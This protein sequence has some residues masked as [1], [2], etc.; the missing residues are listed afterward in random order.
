[1][2]NENRSGTNTVKGSRDYYVIDIM[3][4]LK[5]LWMRAWIIVLAGII[6]AGIG[7]SVAAF[8]ITPQY[9]SSVMLY[10]NNSSFSLG[11]TNFSISSSE[12]MAAQS[13]VKTYSVILKNRTTLDK[14]I[15]KSGVEYDY[16]TLYHMITASAVNETEIMRVTVVSADPYEAA[17]IA[18]CIAEVLPVRIAE[19]IEGSS[20]EVV[21]RAVANPQKIS[22]SITK[23]TAVGL[24][25]GVLLSAA[26]LC[27]IAIMDGTVHDEEYVLN[28]YDYPVL[29]KIPD[30][31]GMGNKRYGYG[32]RRYGYYYRKY[33]AYSNYGTYG[34]NAQNG[35]DGEKGGQA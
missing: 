24:M 13:L 5:A 30:L 2:D 29:A 9:S 7:F 14:V 31:V 26:V 33:G 16:N 25:L 4:V 23:Y 19:I 34:Q 21:D 27:V 22:P 10:V 15:E 6:A 12:I 11:N 3:H 35:G 28:T 20:M 32:Y 17:R 8:V 1:M 18:N